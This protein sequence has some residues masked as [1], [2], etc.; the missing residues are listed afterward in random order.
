[1][2]TTKSGRRTSTQQ[3]LSIL[4]SVQKIMVE[5]TEGLQ[6]PYPDILDLATSEKL[7]LYK[8]SI[9]GLPQSNRYYLTISEWTDFY[10]ELED[11]V[12]TFVLKGAV[13]II[14]FRYGVH[15]STEFKNTIL[16]YP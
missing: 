6:E 15:L 13:L 12:S 4:V 11:A 16:S 10:Q 7:K 14:T 5:P 3:E 2:V 1:M 9:V 8:K